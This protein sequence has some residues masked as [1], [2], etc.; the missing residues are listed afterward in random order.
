MIR[1]MD[2]K[3]VAG[4]FLDLPVLLVII[5]AMTLF[6]MTFTNAYFDYRDEIENMK[7]YENT[8]DLHRSIQMYDE[9]QYEYED[10]FKLGH[11]CMEKLG[12]MDSETIKKDI[13]TDSRYDFSVIIRNYGGEENW[14]FVNEDIPERAETYIFYSPVTLVGDTEYD[15]YIGQLTVILWEG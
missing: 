8:I 5:L 3:G 2:D 15:N 12:S 7:K 9:L 13:T 10:G 1:K 4:F 14:T 11:F 6:I